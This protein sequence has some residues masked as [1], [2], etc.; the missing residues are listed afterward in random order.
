MDPITTN[1][2]ISLFTGVLSSYSV[3]AIKHFFGKAVELD[4]EIENKIKTAKTTF[5]L[6]CIF[7]EATGVI[8]AHAKDD[9][10]EIDDSMLQA[11]KGIRFDHGNGI[12]SISGS[13]ISSSVIQYGGQEGNSG[14]TLITNTISKG[15]GSTVKVNSS[16]KLK[17][18]AKLIQR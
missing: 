14:E 6:E 2:L 8:D 10:I 5:D 17:G 12:I 11:I 16:L 18:S 3:D 1:I 7:N 4:P 9:S 13:E 15:E